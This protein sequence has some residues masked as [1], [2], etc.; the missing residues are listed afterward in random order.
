MGAG[1]GNFQDTNAVKFEMEFVDI[2]EVVQT[3]SDST[4]RVV[5]TAATLALRFWIKLFVVTL[6]ASSS[7]IIAPYTSAS[8]EQTM[9]DA[10]L[11]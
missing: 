6:F 5:L 11:L 3:G 10:A 9:P 8:N 1:Q 4:L 2:H 7:V